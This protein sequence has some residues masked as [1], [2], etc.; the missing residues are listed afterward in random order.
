MATFDGFEEEGPDMQRLHRRL[1]ATPLE[2]LDGSETFHYLALVHDFI[3]SR[4][5]SL[6]ANDLQ[7]FS[8]V[9]QNKKLL[10][11]SLCIMHFLKDEAFSPYSRPVAHWVHVLKQKA[12]ELMVSEP[13]SIYVDDIDRREEFIRVVLQ[14]FNLRPLGETPA[15]ATDRL[16]A[17]S[18]SERLKVIAATQASEARARALREAL[19]EERAREAADKMSRE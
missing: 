16:Q 3:F 1:V 13:L 15:Q 7:A 9:C 14:G 6:Q 5:N 2:L 8:E 19:A 12:K 11:L 17:V 10:A 4:D 18:S